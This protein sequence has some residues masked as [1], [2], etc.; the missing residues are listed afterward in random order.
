MPVSTS[1]E[2]NDNPSS[3]RAQQLHARNDTDDDDDN[4]DDTATIM[5]PPTPGTGTIDNLPVLKSTL[6]T[7]E[8]LKVARP[9]VLPFMLPLFV[10]Y[11]AEV[12]SRISPIQKV[13][14]LEL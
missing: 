3:Q 9:L 12:K 2:T 1:E 8:K 11:F 10:V 5:L 6:S 7:R 13:F 14:P 4:V